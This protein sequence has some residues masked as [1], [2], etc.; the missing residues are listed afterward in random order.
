[1]RPSEIVRPLPNVCS[2]RAMSRTFEWTFAVDAKYLF[3]Y[4]GQQTLNRHTW[5]HLNID[6][7]I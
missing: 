5:I 4:L 1:M 3:Q 7:D 2:N 6:Q